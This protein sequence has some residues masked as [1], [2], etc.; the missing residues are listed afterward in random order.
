MFELTV[1]AA[2]G[3]A[4]NSK[5]A[6]WADWSDGKDFQIV[7]IGGSYGRYINSEDAT[8]AGLACVLV[9][10]GKDYAKSASVNLIKGRM[11]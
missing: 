6:I 7:S 5:A 8:R 1:I 3:R 9:R 11:N 2:Y 4:Y 10:Y